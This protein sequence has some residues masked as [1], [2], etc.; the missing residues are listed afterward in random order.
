MQIDV[1]T[2]WIAEFAG[3]NKASDLDKMAT[4]PHRSALHN[5]AQPYFKLAGIV[6]ISKLELLS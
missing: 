4:H 2:V 3:L 1:K 5:P 6:R